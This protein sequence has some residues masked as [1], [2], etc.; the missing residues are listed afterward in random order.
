M[1]KVADLPCLNMDNILKNTVINFDKRHFST[2]RLRIKTSHKD[3]Y[4]AIDYCLTLSTIASYY[5]L[6]RST[7][8]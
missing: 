1:G 5:R 6:C 3:L 4:Y 2:T 8:R 7:N